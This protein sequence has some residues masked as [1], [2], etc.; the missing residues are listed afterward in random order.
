MAPGPAPREAGVWYQSYPSLCHP[1]PTP[2]GSWK[3]RG[4]EPPGSGSSGTVDAAGTR[5]IP[6]TC[7]SLAPILLPLLLSLFGQDGEVRIECFASVF[8]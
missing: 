2:G 7:L 5:N 1:L 8:K 6:S 3:V 4:S